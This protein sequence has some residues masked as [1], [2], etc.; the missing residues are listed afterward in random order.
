MSGPQSQRSF[1][2]CLRKL[3]A[4]IVVYMLEYKGA[5]ICVFSAFG[6]DLIMDGLCYLKPLLN[7]HQQTVCIIHNAEQHLL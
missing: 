4:V 2:F 1:K 3:S 5:I 7:V 6:Y